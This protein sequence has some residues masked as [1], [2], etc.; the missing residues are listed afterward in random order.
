MELEEPR[1]GK[2]H[3]HS[4]GSLILY[5][6]TDVEKTL[7]PS[8]YMSHSAKYAEFCSSLISLDKNGN[9]MIRQKGVEKKAKKRENPAEL[10]GPTYS[11][12]Q[13]RIIQP[14]KNMA[15]EPMEARKSNHKNTAL[16]RNPPSFQRQTVTVFKQIP[17]KILT[18][19]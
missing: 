12:L 19:E 8:K 6:F 11:R 14:Y 18:D 17:A 5:V 2:P 3:D 13:S 10:E 7:F 16:R 4:V 15:S 9:E 1:G